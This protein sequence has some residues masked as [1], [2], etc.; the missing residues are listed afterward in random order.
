VKQSYNMRRLCNKYILIRLNSLASDSI[1]AWKR[2]G[3][4]L[5]VAGTILGVHTS[6]QQRNLPL[7]NSHQC[8][9]GAGGDSIGRGYLFSCLLYLS[10]SQIIKVT[11]YIKLK[12]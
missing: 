10:I 9:K 11:G 7:L 5:T 6:G 12:Q 2:H 4:T 3:V 1:I 8:T